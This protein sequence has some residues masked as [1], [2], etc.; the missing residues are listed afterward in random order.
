MH[1][2]RLSSLVLFGAGLLSAQSPNIV[3]VMPDDL[4]VPLMNAAL[5]QGLM[6]NVQKYIVTPGTTFDRYYVS[7]AHGCPTREA[8]WTGQY[9]KN[10]LLAGYNNKCSVYQAGSVTP[11][12]TWMSGYNRALLGKWGDGY[13]YEDVNHDGVVDIKDAQFC[14]A[15][16]EFC[17]I[18]PFYQAQVNGQVPANNGLLA[19]D[20]PNDYQYYVNNGG[21]LAYHGTTPQDYQA[22]VLGNASV[23]FIQN[24]A[25]TKPQVPLLMFLTYGAPHVET[26]YNPDP[27]PGYENIYALTVHP[28]PGSAPT[29][30]VS[31]LQDP[32]FNAAV[33]T[34]K[35][36]YIT[37]KPLMNSNDLAAI[38]TQWQNRMEA[39]A[40]VDVA[41][42]QTVAAL[43]AA[44]QLQNTI[45]I[46]VSDNG[47]MDGD[48]RLG[49]K[50]APYNPS[51]QTPLYVSVGGG[52]TSHAQVGDN[53]L[54][55]TILQ[56]AGKTIPST[57][58]GTSF[59][60]LLS[61]PTLTWRKRYFLQ[62]IQEGLGIDDITSYN[63]VRSSLDDTISV[64]SLFT[65]YS[66]GESEFYHYTTDPNATQNLNLTPAWNSQVK[67]MRN[68]ITQW[69]T[70]TGQACHNLEFN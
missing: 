12:S 53:D 57:V 61:N 44:N 24:A 40:G 65:E 30:D 45:F 14:P 67:Q 39:L 29:T 13:G 32:T 11:L 17:F 7:N 43:Q 60:P 42:G 21:V 9:F 25:A 56:L 10:H 20:N 55:P 51:I 69:L 38:Q 6:P 23:Q 36:A 52:V 26:N 49:G 70:C 66:T 16:W 5:A 8:Y 41:F 37:S 63:G 31:Y 58:D 62:Y 19:Q 3:V 68:L 35:P 22:T 48:F 2:F 59:V 15:N 28:P 50:L 47:W 4:N 54:L 33:L 64:D 18:I 27:L 34:G 1:I 46:F